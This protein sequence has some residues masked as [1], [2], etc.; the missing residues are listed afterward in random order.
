MHTPFTPFKILIF[1]QTCIHTFFGVL[2]LD[3]NLDLDLEC[4]LSHTL[5]CFGLLSVLG[6]SALPRS[7]ENLSLGVL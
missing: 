6:H 2:D 3:R 7:I 1:I 5:K 4:L